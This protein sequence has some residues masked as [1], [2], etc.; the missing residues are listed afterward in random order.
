MSS[1]K[2]FSD[3][4]LKKFGVDAEAVKDEYGC[5]PVSHFDIYNGETVTIRDKKGVL[6]F[7]T[8]MTK[9]QFFQ[10]YGKSKEEDCK[11]E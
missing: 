1:C 10:C 9:E 8:Q 7:D 4:Y 5:R 2:K 3:H 6:F 11:Y